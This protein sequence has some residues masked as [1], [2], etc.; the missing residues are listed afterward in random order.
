[1]F[2]VFLIISLA[3]GLGFLSCFQFHW[4]ELLA[5]TILLATTVFFLIKNQRTGPWSVPL[6]AAIL[7]FISM[8]LPDHECLVGNWSRGWT[9]FQG[10]H[11]LLAGVGLYL[12]VRLLLIKKPDLPDRIDL[13]GYT[14]FWVF[15][16]LLGYVITVMIT[17]HIQ[18][19]TVIIHPRLFLQ[20]TSVL[21]FYLLC[22][23]VSLLPVSTRRYLYFGLVLMIGLIL[24]INACTIIR[25]RTLYQSALAANEAGRYQEAYELFGRV[26][27]GNKHLKWESW[28]REAYKSL[29]I[30]SLRTGEIHSAEKQFQNALSFTRHDPIVL[31]G[32]ATCQYQMGQHKEAMLSLR[33][34]LQEPIDYEKLI[35]SFQPPVVIMK[36][37]AIILKEQKAYSHAQ[38]IMVKTQERANDG[39][40]EY[41]L[42]DCYE[43]MGKKKLA[44]R[45]YQ[46]SIDLDFVSP[47]LYHRLGMIEFENNN[48]TKA[49]QLARKAKMISPFYIDA[50]DLLEKIY[51]ATG[52]EKRIATIK[53]TRQ[54]YLPNQTLSLKTQN[55]ELMGFR[56]EKNI[57]KQGEPLIIYFY[58]RLLSD[59]TEKYEPIG[60]ICGSGQNLYQRVV[61]N[62]LD[63]MH[64]DTRR[65]Y[66]G[67]II[68]SR[69]F[70]DTV[71]FL[72]GLCTVSYFMPGDV[73][74]DRRLKQMTLDEIDNDKFK[75]F[76]SVSI[77]PHIY[78]KKNYGPHVVG[79]L[80]DPAQDQKYLN[81]YFY[82]AN[83]YSL[84]IPTQFPPQA[85]TASS[86]ILI[87][88]LSFSEY[89]EQGEEIARIVVT[90]TDNQQWTWSVKAGIDSSEWAW[91]CPGMRFRHKRARIAHS[92]TVE[93]QGRSFEGHKYFSQYDFGRP[94]HID[95]IK[96]QYVAPLGC[97]EVCNLIIQGLQRNLPKQIP[98]EIQKF[99]E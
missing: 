54:A 42:G 70:L 51:Q 49:L 60:L 62:L 57:L 95:T 26:L 77:L 19:L 53:S 23:N 56:I 75:S 84:D 69:C 81:V 13:L 45:H 18:H 16:V 3:F 33:T 76:V 52:D 85:I 5:L 37:I 9:I 58:S 38:T 64:K 22:R 96:I 17:G 74:G 86:M 87:S 90:D 71:T 92:W 40:L 99:S 83:R 31:L 61:Y 98:T 47:E 12:L 25:V 34:M 14:I 67:D 20:I 30:L 80:C 66:R 63:R 79:H 50:Y 15:T 4:Q 73:E 11:T 10:V 88:S 21:A 91:D 39:E 68:I 97:L 2:Q 27:T 29:G 82:L 41:H 89:L 6:S 59:S 36:H 32:L 43:Q 46:R 93:M 72:P 55:I 78:H 1:M 48:M 44:V 24:S 8:Q 35:S 28:L 65:F 7:Y 94:I